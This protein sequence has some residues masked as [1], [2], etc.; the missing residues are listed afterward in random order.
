MLTI[1]YY[2]ISF[3]F[4]LL[5]K[6]RHMIIN[7]VIIFLTSVLVSNDLSPNR[8]KNPDPEKEIFRLINHFRK[9]RGLPRLRYLKSQQREVDQWAKHISERF[10][11]ADSGFTC[12]NIASNYEG[13][14]ELFYQWRDSRPHRRNML[15]KRIRYSTIGVYRYGR[16][17]LGVFRGYTDKK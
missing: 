1:A 2:A 13:P 12:E 17:Y 14:E 7:A 8:D 6:R 15:L 16:R 9:S 10:E 5:F 4:I 3:Y 11:H